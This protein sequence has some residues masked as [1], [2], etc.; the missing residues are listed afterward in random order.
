MRIDKAYFKTILE[1]M[2]DTNTPT[3]KL[4]SLGVC[5][6]VDY[7]F[8][9][10]ANY[11]KMLPESEKLVFH[12]KILLDL[13]VFEVLHSEISSTILFSGGKDL[14]FKLRLTA[15]GQEYAE[16]FIHNFVEKYPT[17]LVLEYKMTGGASCHVGV[18]SISGK[19]RFNK[20]D[21]RAFNFATYELLKKDC[22]EFWGVHIS[23]INLY[24]G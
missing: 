17:L 1:Q 16:K 23:N 7:R 8:T 19:S 15:F 13:K 5:K 12:F 14:E 18:I 21:N 4:D 11:Y 9:E 10:H 24:E 3:F 22:S 20:I 2:L 6:D